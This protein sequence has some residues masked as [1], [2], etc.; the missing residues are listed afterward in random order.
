MLSIRLVSLLLTV[1]LLTGCALSPQTVSINPRIDLAEINQ[2]GSQQNLSLQIADDRGTQIV[3]TRG[4]VYPETSE[5]STGGDI[6]TPIRNVL[7]KALR[8]MGYNVVGENEQSTADLKV[9]VD[10]LTYKTKSE[11]VMKAIETAASIRVVASKGN[12]EYTGRYRGKRTTE[13]LKAPDEDRNAEMINAAISQ[14]LQRL[15]NDHELHK[16]LRS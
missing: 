8:D 14:V 2:Q 11:N 9:I 15:L 16:F 3:G 7:T 13:V 5:I 6:K 10:N 4:G 1:S 12:R